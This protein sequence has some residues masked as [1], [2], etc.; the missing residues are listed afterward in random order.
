MLGPGQREEVSRGI[1]PR[2]ERML[3]FISDGVSNDSIRL[4]DHI[5]VLQFFAGKYPPVWLWLSE[6]SE[7]SGDMEHAKDYV[8]RYLEGAS[9]GRVVAWRRLAE[10]CRRQDD[11]AGEMHALVGMSEDDGAVE[12]VSDAAN[13]VNHLFTDKPKLFDNDEKIMLLRRLVQLFDVVQGDANGTDLS[14]L[15]WLKLRLR[16]EEGARL[17]VKRGLTIEPRNTFLL[18]LAR[19]LSVVLP[20]L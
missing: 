12:V 15:A 13:R 5:R 9:E 14:R 2:I 17:V 1:G 18:G 10:L 16:D 20:A 4:A 7:D 8:R 11:S 19:R 6:M 3:S